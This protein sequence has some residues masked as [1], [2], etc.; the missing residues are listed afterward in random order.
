M[1]FVTPVQLRAF[2]DEYSVGSGQCGGIGKS[3]ITVVG[4][5]RS[6]R[7]RMATA[8]ELLPRDG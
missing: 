4:D 8:S 1:D 6:G 2:G 5:S 3:S 7:T